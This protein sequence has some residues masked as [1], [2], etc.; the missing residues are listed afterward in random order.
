MRI[1]NSRKTIEPRVFLRVPF[2]RNHVC[3]LNYRATRSN[4]GKHAPVLCRLD[5]RVVQHSPHA[6]SDSTA[7]MQPSMATAA[8]LRPGLVWSL[9]ARVMR[10][11][12]YL[13]SQYTLPCG[14]VANIFCLCLDIRGFSVSSIYEKGGT[15]FSVQAN[16]AISN[17]NLVKLRPWCAL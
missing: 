15:V 11:K 1:C 8:G 16:H 13:R 17:P 3:H 5:A 10:N 14:K 4:N 2:P 9:E 7:L 12:Q 6:S